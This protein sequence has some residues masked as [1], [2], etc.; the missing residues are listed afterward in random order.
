MKLSKN[1][2]AAQT[3]TVAGNLIMSF[4]SL[5]LHKELLT[6]VEKLGFVQPTPIQKQAIPIILQRQ[7]I[8]GIAQTGTG[9]TAAFVLPI[10][11]HNIISQNK[12]DRK[13]I[14]A[15]IVAPTRELAEQI[16]EVIISFGGPSG[17]RSATIFGGVS[18]SRQI[19]ELNK[20]VDIVV[21]CPGR[22][23]DHLA[24]KTIDLSK[25]E[26]YVLDEADQMLDMGF[27]PD[28]KKITS[29]LPLKRQTLLF[30]A[31][32][33]EQIR[34]LAMTIQTKPKQIE[35]SRSEATKQVTH[36]L[37][38]IDQKQKS[39]LLKH[40]IRNENSY[41][42]L[43]FTRTKQRTIY[44]AQKLAKGGLNVT[45]LHGNLSINQRRN[46]VDGFK[47]GKYQV[48]VATDIA[49][50]GIDIASISHVINFDV[51]DTPETY[52]HRIGRTGRAANTGIAYT[53]ADKAEMK[54][55][56]QIEKLLKKKIVI[57]SHS[58]S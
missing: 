15:L 2:P 27:L 11:H 44:L 22:L 39:N 29:M 5:E 34:K 6:R 3:E 55:I 25:V 33:P 40:I 50:R 10:L 24:R 32:M 8:T 12:N 9:K 30:S 19:K 37:Y 41:S 53:F 18:I 1:L 45:A 46:A 35:V 17:I 7:D 52:I 47:K 43:V 31:T 51:P 57:N 36:S 23:L 54:S 58:F 20:G 38:T 16:N 21:G 48:M 14:K 28:I 13:S 56:Y 4:I 42:T 49:A 26:T